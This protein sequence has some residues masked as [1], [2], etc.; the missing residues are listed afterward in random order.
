MNLKAQRKK[1]DSNRWMQRS[2]A[3]ASRRAWTR[4]SY[5]ATI[6]NWGGGRGQLRERL[7]QPDPTHP[8]HA[9]RQPR[10]SLGD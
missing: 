5:L 3:S 4:I 1:T 7:T 2:L 6:K 9:T 8:D 10:P